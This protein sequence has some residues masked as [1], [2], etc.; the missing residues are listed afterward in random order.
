MG[1]PIPISGLTISIYSFGLT[2]RNRTYISDTEFCQAQHD[3]S[4]TIG[5]TLDNTL[6]RC[7]PNQSF[8]GK[9]H[10]LLATYFI[11]LVRD[12][13]E[14]TVISKHPFSVIIARELLHVLIS[15]L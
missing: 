14:L 1:V 2:S 6:P 15:N 9:L 7:S 12:G 5:R 3:R 8:S 11:L 4:K 10:T 13:F